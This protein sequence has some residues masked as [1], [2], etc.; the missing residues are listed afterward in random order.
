MVTADNS[1][2]NYR[3]SLEVG[4]VAT[5]FEHSH[6]IKILLYVIFSKI[7]LW[8]TEHQ[9][10]LAV[11]FSIWSIF[12]NSVKEM[13]ATP[14]VQFL[15]LMHKWEWFNSNNVDNE[16]QHLQCSYSNNVYQ[17]LAG[18]FNLNGTATFMRALIMAATSTKIYKAMDVKNTTSVVING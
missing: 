4:S 14:T 5:D 6:L 8:W 1:T 17:Q 11:Y 3:I 10:L 16:I 13:R 18:I 2:L 12:F 15:I 9:Y 7:W